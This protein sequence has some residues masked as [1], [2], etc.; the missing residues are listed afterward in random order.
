MDLGVD[1]VIVAFRPN[2]AE[3][4]VTSIERFHRDV[5]SAFAG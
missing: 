3:G 5:V 1:E 4:L 2:D